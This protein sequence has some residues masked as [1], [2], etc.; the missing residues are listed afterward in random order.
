MEGQMVTFRDIEK[1]YE[2]NFAISEN[3]KFQA[4]ARSNRMIGEWAAQKLGLVGAQAEAYSKEVV[5]IDF[6]NSGTDAV[7]TKIRRDFNAKGVRQSDHQIRRTMQEQLA[8]ALADLR[9]GH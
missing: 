4:R 1:G 7:F 8:C 9:A 6:E 3:L 2:S 5:M